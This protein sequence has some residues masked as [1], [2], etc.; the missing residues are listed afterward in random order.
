M[1]NFFVQIGSKKLEE[2]ILQF[3]KKYEKFINYNAEARTYLKEEVQD[4]KSFI[5]EKLIANYHKKYKYSNWDTIVK[6]IIKR[7]AVDFS[8]GRNNKVSKL[9]METD[10]NGYLQNDGVDTERKDYLDFLGEHKVKF[11]DTYEIKDFFIEVCNKIIRGGTL[12]EFTDIEK[13]FS[14]FFKECLQ[15][16]YFY[17]E[18][19]VKMFYE[20]KD[21]EK[22]FKLSFYKR[23]LQVC[24]NINSE[25]V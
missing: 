22:K 15:S 13:S 12:E 10:L 2:E 20:E 8:K 17:L 16:D 21:F 11:S 14:E 5:I 19:I 25:V 9:V 6:S 24:F 1:R 3:I 7:K 4:C 18:E 23:K